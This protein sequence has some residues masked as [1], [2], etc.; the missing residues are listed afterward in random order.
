MKESVIILWLKNLFHF[1]TRKTF[2]RWAQIQ[3]SGKEKAKI[4]T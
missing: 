3:V 2:A 1:L 4:F